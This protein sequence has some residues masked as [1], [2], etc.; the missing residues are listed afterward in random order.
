MVGLVSLSSNPVDV[1]LAFSNGDALWIGRRVATKQR[2][3]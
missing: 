3:T 1:V 2:L